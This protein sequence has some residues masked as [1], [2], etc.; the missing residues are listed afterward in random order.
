MMDVAMAA[1]VSQATVSLVLNGGPGARFSVGT[2]NRV[3]RAAE[4]LGYQ[5]SRRSKRRVSGEQVVIGFVTDEVT[6]D[7]WMALAFDGARETALENGCTVFLTVARGDT[8]ADIL[9]FEQ[10]AQKS[11]LGIIYGTILTRRVEPSPTLLKLR[12]VLLNCYDA[13]KRLPSVLP[14]DLVGGRVATERLIQGGRKRI[15]LINGQQG[16][17]ASRDRLKGYRQ[18]LASNDMPFDPVL[19]RPGNWEPSSGYEMTKR[20]MALDRP[21]DAIFCCNDLMAVGCYDALRELGCR[22]PM[23]VAVIGFD[24]REIAQSM[25]P[26]L[27]T[28]ELPQREMGVIAAGVLIDMAAGLA[29]AGTQIKVEC[30]LVDRASVEQTRPRHSNNALARRSTR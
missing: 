21:P 16:L 26:P 30:P 22:V 1:G 28:L 20:L 27:T 14:G 13:A 23:D 25:R 2:Q 11:L 24:D 18:A 10:F 29:A 7:P 3:K 8:E 19:V 12:T 5:F 15:A 9:A 6:T 4:E 17:D